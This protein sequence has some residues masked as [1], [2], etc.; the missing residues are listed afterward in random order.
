MRA[1]NILAFLSDVDASYARTVIVDEVRLLRQIHELMRVG[2]E[3]PSRIADRLAVGET[4]VS[5]FASFRR[6][7][8]RSL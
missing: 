3:Q 1:V 2:L 4:I 5:H 8:Q 6:R 7:R